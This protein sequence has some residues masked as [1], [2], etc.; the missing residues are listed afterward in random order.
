MTRRISVAVPTA[1][2]RAFTYRVAG[3]PPCRPGSRVLVPFGRRVVVGIVLDRPAEDLDEARLRPV[4]ADL[5]EGRAPTLDPD[6]LALAE[7]IAD[8]Y[9]APIGEVVRAML[10]GLLARGDARRV[11]RTGV[12]LDGG[13]AELVRLVE[14]VAAAGPKGLAAAGLARLGLSRPFV[15]L[16]RAEAAGLVA[17]RWQGAPTERMA[18]FVRATAAARRD[19]LSEAALAKAAGRSKLRRRLL[20]RLQDALDDA[21]Q[22]GEPSAAFVPLSALR[23]ETPRARALLEPLAQAGLV[24]FEQRPR[25]PDP[26]ASSSAPPSAPPPLTQEQAAALDVLAEKLAA[27]TFGQALLHGITGSG[28][29][30]VYLRV[31]ER[32]RR[33]GGGALVL[34]PEIA[35]TPQLAA[36]FRARFSDQVAVLHSGLTPRQR[37]DAWHRIRRGDAPIVIGVRSAVFAPI[38]DLRVIVVDEEHDPSF[39]QEEGVRYHARDVALV[40]A[41]RGG[42]LVVLGSATP[43]LETYHRA[44]TGAVA[45]LRL[46]HRPTPRPLPEVALVSLAVHRPN[47]ASQLS[48][49]LAD[50]IRSTV[51]AGEQVILFLNRR[52]F[53]PSLQCEDCGGFVACPDCTGPAMTYHLR[54]NRLVCHL[55]GRIEAVPPACPACGAA[56]L[57]A[58][59]T[60]TERVEI[61]LGRVVP[62]VPVLRLD[63]DTAYGARL[64]RTLD[65]FRRGEAPILVGTQ[66]LTKGHDFPNV[67]LVGVV[68]ADH[69]L[70]IPDPRAAE[71]VF[72]LIT[73]VAGR[74][75][76]GDRPGRVIVQAYAV[77]HPALVRAAAH[78]YDGFAE[79]ELAARRE[80]ANPPFGHLALVRVVGEHQGAVEARAA[81]LAEGLRARAGRAGD[82]AVL[83]PVPSFPA[84]INRRY[85]VQILLR[86][87][88]RPDLR[89]L[90]AA[91]RP[92]LGTAAKG[93]RTVV[94]VDPQTL[95]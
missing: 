47:P 74:A 19:V 95:S 77:E 29:T 41:R 46:R 58:T 37:L 9:L 73:Q 93:V 39:K 36:R 76:R 64:H 26:F 35:L 83:G 63:R 59:G 6:L 50:A 24:A 79:V 71:R 11:V 49:L 91:L 55:C 82:V 21:E 85:R 48:G 42:A 75:G 34:V 70:S 27:R 84:R 14:A 40:R 10:P 31:I 52:G 2:D 65:A 32:V 43:S 7:W 12:P 22:T 4:L 1:V 23:S 38:R 33:A 28:K 18:S 51:A 81:R 92:A 45:H 68:R 3:D 88:N 80:L 72:Q 78:D 44:R 13:P 56:A 30:E 25:A 61:E 90:L 69:A 89:R 87:P 17:S 94:D 53:A 20:D 5:D 86:S 60:G 66:M 57:A 67:T 16:E 54:R 15:W 62:G 8:Y